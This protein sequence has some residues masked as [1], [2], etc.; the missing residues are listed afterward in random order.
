MIPCMWNHVFIPY[1]NKLAFDHDLESQRY[2]G[3]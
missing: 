3:G 1:V 2:V